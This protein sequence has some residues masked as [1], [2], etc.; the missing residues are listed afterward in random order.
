MRRICAGTSDENRRRSFVKTTI[1]D[2]P[3]LETICS[4]RAFYGPARVGRASEPVELCRQETLPRSSGSRAFPV[5]RLSTHHRRFRTAA[6]LTTTVAGWAG[7]HELDT[8]GPAVERAKL[9]QRVLFPDIAFYAGRP[10]GEG[11]SSTSRR[12]RIRQGMDISTAPKDEGKMGWT[13]RN[14]TGRGTGLKTSRR[15][16]AVSAAHNWPFRG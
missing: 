2:A 5:F 6:F 4:V 10:G 9:W 14:R 13:S 3:L 8:P 7:G 15:S 16:M 11:K 12:V 1:E